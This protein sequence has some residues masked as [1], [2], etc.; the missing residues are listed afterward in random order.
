MRTTKRFTPTVLARFLREGRGTGAYVE[1]VPWHGVSRGDPASRGRSHLHNWRGRQQ[2][3]LSDGEWDCLLFTSLDPTVRDS[4][5]Q[6]RLSLVSDIHDLS[7]Y[8]MVDPRKR[9]PGTLE[10]ADLLGIKHP[11]TRDKLTVDPW[12][13][14]TDRLNVYGVSAGANFLLSA[15]AVAAKPDRNLTPRQWDLLFLEKTYWEI[16]GVPWIL[17]T[18]ELFD[19]RV[20]NFL[21]STAGWAFDDEVDIELIAIAKSIHLAHPASPLQVNLQRLACKLGNMELAQRAFWQAVWSEALPI[22]LRMGWNLNFPYS[23]LSLSDFR[24]LNPI[25]MRRSSWRP[26]N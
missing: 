12:V 21:R 1:Y 19:P 22:D 24:N 11:V 8:T 5:E 26:R 14:T 9:Y 18:P 25:T 3:L 2:A 7:A 10:L 6:K 20:S 4:P 13:F 23:L 15:L 16:R 17:F